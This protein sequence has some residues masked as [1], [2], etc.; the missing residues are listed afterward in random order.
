VINAWP[1]LLPPLEDPH[2]LAI[3]RARGR[4]ASQVL[5]RWALQH[6]VAVIPKAS[7]RERILENSMLFDFE[8]APVEMAALDGLATLSESTHEQLRPPWSP[9]VYG[10][11]GPAR[12][13]G[14]PAPAGA[15]GFREAARD[16]QCRRDLPGVRLEPF[17]LGGGGHQLSQC[18]AACASHAQ[19]GFITFYHRTGFCHMFKSCPEQEQAG[20]GAVTYARL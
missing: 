8:L 9:D 10:L 12:P 4:T 13:Q 20:D 19:C 11:Q 17:S 5:H 6:G 16:R 14:A 1:H 18:Q 2:V 7:S 3:A 15:A